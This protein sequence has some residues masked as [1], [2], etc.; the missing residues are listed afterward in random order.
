MEEGGIPRKIVLVS[1]IMTTSDVMSC[2][3]LINTENEREG[4][5]ADRNH[6]A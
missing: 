1:H 4:R 5:K 2:K 6:A 3:C